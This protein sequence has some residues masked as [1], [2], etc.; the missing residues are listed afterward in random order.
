MI[1]LSLR[2]I[3]PSVNHAQKV[4]NAFSEI[5]YILVITLTRCSVSPLLLNMREVSYFVLEYQ[6]YRIYPQSLCA[7]LLT[8][9]EDKSKAIPVQAW[10]GS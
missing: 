7:L 9:S 5:I 3:C 2:G 6:L 1:G 10:T 8:E 4:I